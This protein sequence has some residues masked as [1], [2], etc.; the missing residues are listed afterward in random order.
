MP[1]I[2]EAL[3][4]KHGYP[5][6]LRAVATALFVLTGP[7]IPLLK[8]QLPPTEQNALSRAD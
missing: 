4:Q 7:L 5:I 3:L 1:F 6:T 2:V 8:G